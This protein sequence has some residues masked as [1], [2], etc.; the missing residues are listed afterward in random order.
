MELYF[1]E[2]YI[3]ESYISQTLCPTLNIITDFIR[4][5]RLMLE[6][7]MCVRGTNGYIVLCVIKQHIDSVVCSCRNAVRGR[8]WQYSNCSKYGHY[9]PHTNI[10]YD[11]YDRI[12]VAV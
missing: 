2:R 10:H 1:Y 3:E 6:P 8:S 12:G 11:I 5:F 4:Y 9:I 7:V